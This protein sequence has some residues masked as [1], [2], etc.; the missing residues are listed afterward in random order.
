MI[1]PHC[2]GV[3]W[4]A[5]PGPLG[6]RCRQCIIK[7]DCLKEF[8]TTRLRD[9]QKSLGPQAQLTDLSS[10]LGV[11]EQAILVAMGFTHK[12]KRFKQTPVL[13]ETAGNGVA[14]TGDGTAPG[15][16]GGPSTGPGIYATGTGAETKKTKK[17][18][19]KKTKK[20]K[21][22]A[23]KKT[24]KRTG[25]WGK[26]THKA[27][28]TREREKHPSI[29]KLT[30]GTVIEVTYKGAPLTA[31]VKKG[32]YVYGDQTFPTLGALTTHIVGGSRSAMKFWKL[33]QAEK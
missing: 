1:K 12:P 13:A 11:D 28:W 21:R 30:P 7:D 29:G 17:T 18:G 5:I 20:T 31:T 27:R 4:E 24:G 15:L 23:K 14:G 16:V 10:A 2:F 33:E 19:S 8:A 6:D 9:A 26:K 32:G 3:W 22:K 25:A